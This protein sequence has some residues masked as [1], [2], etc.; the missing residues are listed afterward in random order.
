MSESQYVA[1]GRGQQH[2]LSGRMMRSGYVESVQ[3]SF[4][5]KMLGIE[6]LR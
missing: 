3:D 2:I 5:M 6:V 4:N 1:K